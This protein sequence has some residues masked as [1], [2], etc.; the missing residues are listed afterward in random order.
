MTAGRPSLAGERQPERDHLFA[1]AGQQ[2]VVD[3]Y[4]MVPGLA[5]AYDSHLIDG[6]S[7][8]STLAGL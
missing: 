1:V 3:Q 4:G 5:L 8:M 2:D 7:V 6:V